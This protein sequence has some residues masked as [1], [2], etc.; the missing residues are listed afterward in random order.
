M[1]YDRNAEETERPPNPAPRSARNKLPRHVLDRRFRWCSL[2]PFVPCTTPCHALRCTL[3]SSVP[4]EDCLATSFGKPACTTFVSS[5]GYDTPVI[6]VL[7]SGQDVYLFSIGQVRSDVNTDWT[8][9]RMLRE[10][11]MQIHVQ[12]V[13]PYLHCNDYCKLISEASPHDWHAGHGMRVSPTSA[14]FVVATWQMGRRWGC[15]HAS[16]Y[17]T[18]TASCLG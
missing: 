10:C 15:S 9:I 5:V 1:G 4:V 3:N 16:T 13:F 7:V 6:G 14:V 2:Q 8:R 17:F 18:M 12:S 11:C